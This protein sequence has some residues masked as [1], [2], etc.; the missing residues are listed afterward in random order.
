MTLHVSILVLSGVGLLGM[1][2]L[3]DAI[4]VILN[5]TVAR[6]AEYFCSTDFISSASIGKI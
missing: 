2:I 5:S 3:N 6:E 1:L 4:I